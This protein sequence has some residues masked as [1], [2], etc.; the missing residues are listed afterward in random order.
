MTIAS[1]A[2]SLLLLTVQA[3]GSVKAESRQ[4]IPSPSPFTRCEA[5]ARQAFGEQARST[6]KDI[7]TLKRTSGRLPDYPALPAGT[8]GSGAAVHELLIRPDGHV[9]RVWTVR[10]ASLQPPF[11]PFGKAIT[12]A[13]QQWRYEPLI[14]DGRAVPVCLI[15]TT[16]IHWR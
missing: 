11:P 16:T 7:A 13:L 9:Q 10:E 12:D 1:L 5:E 6:P 3:S 14:I 8:R 15:I 2:S 4:A